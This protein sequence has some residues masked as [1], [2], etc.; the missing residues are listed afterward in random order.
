MSYA[1]LDVFGDADG[2]GGGPTVGVIVEL[3]VRFKVS[4]T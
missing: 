4:V 2:A 1:P 3:T